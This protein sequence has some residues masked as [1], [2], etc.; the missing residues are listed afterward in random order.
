MTNIGREIA[1]LRRMTP[2]EL[3][4]RYAEVFGEPTRSGNREAMVKRIAWRLQAQAEGGLSERARR[5]AEQLARDADLRLTSPRDSNNGAARTAATNTEKPT[6]IAVTFT[7][8]P[9]RVGKSPTAKATT[10]ITMQISRPC[11]F[12]SE[13]PLIRLPRFFIPSNR[14]VVGGSEAQMMLKMP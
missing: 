3:R 13:R 2:K 4:A 8:S 9:S 1:A 14:A 11:S 6:M 5:R 7:G 12:F 10:A